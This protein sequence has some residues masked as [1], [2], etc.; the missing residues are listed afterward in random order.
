LTCP[1]CSGVLWEIKEG[2][3]LRY[4]CHTGHAFAAELVNIALEDAVSR[5]LAVALRSF[6]ERGEIARNLER[7]AL[8]SAQLA[9][10]TMWRQRIG[11]IERQAEII[12]DAITR[13]NRL[14][15]PMRADA[16]A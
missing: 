11:D 16:S 12:R 13:L 1:E 9:S 10:A 3:S 2:D 4:R 15:N 8:A 5:A 14:A 6:E 7:Q